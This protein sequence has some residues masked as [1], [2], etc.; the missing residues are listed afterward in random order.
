MYFKMFWFYHLDP[1]LAVYITNSEQF[2][3][4]LMRSREV[5]AQGNVIGFQIQ[6]KSD[7]IILAQSKMVNNA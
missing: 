2:E 1:N 6:R 3:Y 5:I 4:L 7:G